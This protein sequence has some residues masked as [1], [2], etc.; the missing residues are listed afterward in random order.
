MALKKFYSSYQLS[1][2]SCDEYFETITNLSDIISHCGGVI[3]NHPLLVE[4]LLKSAD[5]SNPDNP[6][7]DETSAAKTVTEEAYMATAFLSGLN[8]DRYGV[9]LN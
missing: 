7:E 4:K 5:P 2:S 6:T 3:G 9:L 8:R 1:S